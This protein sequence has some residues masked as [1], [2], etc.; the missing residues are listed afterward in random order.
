MHGENRVSVTLQGR[1][2]DVGT[3]SSFVPRDELGFEHHVPLRSPPPGLVAIEDDDLPRGRRQHSG[4]TSAGFFRTLSITPA[5]L[6]HPPMGLPPVVEVG[7]AVGQLRGARIEILNLTSESVGPLR[8]A[9][10]IS[11]NEEC[12][13]KLDINNGEIALRAAG[14]WQHFRKG[15]LDF[16]DSKSFR[17]HTEAGSRLSVLRVTRLN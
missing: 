10:N 7:R 14:Y 12:R 1:Y 16:D 4:R 15:S 8:N 11:R 6:E 2:K 3:R 5:S 9:E 13:W 17:S